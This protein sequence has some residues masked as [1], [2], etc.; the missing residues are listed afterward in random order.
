MLKRST[1]KQEEYPLN[2][3]NYP[4]SRMKRR[5]KEQRAAKIQNFFIG[6]VMVTV[7]ISLLFLF[8]AAMQLYYYNS[9]SFWGF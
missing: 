7:T 1:I 2:R 5:A 6:A 8:Q 4:L 3:T 9:Q